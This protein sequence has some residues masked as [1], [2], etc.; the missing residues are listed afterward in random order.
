MTRSRAAD[1]A[2]GALGMLLLLTVLAVILWFSISTPSAET[3]HTSSPT[4][5]TAGTAPD[6]PPSDLGEGEIWL[7][8]IDVTS[9]IVVL[10]DSSLLNVEALGHGARSGPDGV[11]VDHLDVRATVPFDVVEEELG[12]NSRVSATSDGQARVDGSV[13]VLGRSLQIVATGTVE[14]RDGLL[15]VEP[16]SIDLGGPDV[17]SRAVA[18]AVRQFV[19]IEH[20]IEGLPPNLVL[21]DVEIEQEGFRAHLS[22]DDVELVGDGS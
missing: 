2:I 16:R 14:V 8:D 15:L 9:D 20:T 6:T 18:G 21:R 22:G 17:V 4:P 1:W 10:P 19:T 11:V 5:V 7:G 13:T 12:R 3:S